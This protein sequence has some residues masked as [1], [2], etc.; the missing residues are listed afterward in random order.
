MKTDYSG[1][2]GGYLFT[3]QLV[4]NLGGRQVFRLRF[5]PHGHT[6]N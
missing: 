4:N 6:A 1:G 5:G 3:H 2:S